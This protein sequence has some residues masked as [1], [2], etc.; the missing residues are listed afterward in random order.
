MKHNIGA[1]D[2]WETCFKNID[3][4]T[5]DFSKS[6]PA[7]SLA[8]FCD[9]YLE[10]GAA[11]LDL[12]CGGGRNV[13]YLAQR[14]Y[15]VFGV[16]IAQ[17][18]VA[19]CKKRFA[20]FN[21]SGFFIQGALD[22]IP[23]PDN[24]FSGV[25]CVAALDHI[26][27]ECAKRSIIEM[28]RVLLNKGMILLTFD[29]PEQDEDIIHEAEVLSDGTLKFVRGKQKGMLFRRYQDEE[30][31]SLIKEQNIITFDHTEN[32]ARVVVCR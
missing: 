24:H 19:F 6:K 8:G 17:A 30:I 32:G 27:H 18:A 25:I 13:H 14:D 22:D 26:T 7:D 9:N 15:R 5:Y 23:F 21:L 1:Q 12:A 20:R 29:H 16:D 11:V 31:K 28:R 2:Y 3:P 10:Q 4:D